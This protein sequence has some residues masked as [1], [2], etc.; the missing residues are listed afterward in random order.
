MK[1]FKKMA[2][3]CMFL[4]LGLASCSD[5]E[6]VEV[7][8]ILSVSPDA[9]IE[10]NATG[11]ESV[12]LTVKTDAEKWAYQAPEW[13]TAEQSGKTLVVNA[14]DNTGTEAR[15]GSIVFTAGTADQ[16]KINVLQHEPDGDGGGD[17][18]EGKIAGSIK[19]EGGTNEMNVT[20][21][22]NET[23]TT[24]KMKIALA[25]APKADV[26][27][28][29]IMD[30]EYLAEYNI[31]NGTS[32]ILLPDEA[33]AATEWQATIAAG[34]K[35]AEVSIPVD[36]ANLTYTDKYLLPLKAEVAEDSEVQFKKSESRVNYIF[37]KVNPREV[38]QMCIM[39][40]NDANPLSV[41]E[42][43]L[44]DGSYFFDA[45]VL[46]SGNMGWDAGTQSVRFNAR[47]GEEVINSNTDA[48]IK[49]WET[50]LKPIHDAGIKVYMGIMPHWTPAGITTLSQKGCK[51]FAEDMAQ[52][53]HDCQMDG[54]FLDE[55]YT[56]GT[57][58]GEWFEP[59]AGGAY[60]AYQM[61]KQMEALCDW[62]TDVSVYTYSLGYGWGTVTD[63]ED[64]TTH[65]LSEYVDSYIANYGGSAYPSGDLTLKNC[66]G[67]SIQL[68]YGNTI[69]ESQAREI[70]ESGY[71]WIMYFA[72]NSDPNH[73]NY[74][75]QATTV[76]QNA[77]RG[78]YDQELIEPTHYYKKI[79]QGMY[80]P[81]RYAY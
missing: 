63:H 36:G 8:N 17:V 22:K 47:T 57:G 31:S 15:S 35:D 64:G 44:E 29:V 20:F 34:S 53:I 6:T 69:S 37:N 27:V 40:F 9:A 77:A 25:E 52:I 19:D 68:N 10:F 12:T 55:E 41:L 50:Y 21:T 16:V 43:K 59:T 74:T 28:N 75:S 67:A 23:N 11:N 56:S 1:L 78:C 3:M 51:W 7:K 61:D 39:E 71:G 76:F 80:D 46:F 13:I 45:L 66:S 38:K 14:K 18:E 32:Y 33:L 62:D 30:K 73:E 54:V 24:V 49:N 2:G 65:Q 79:G 81:T 26:N 42:Y 58:K 48:L 60:F 4:A 5:D 70:K 72:F